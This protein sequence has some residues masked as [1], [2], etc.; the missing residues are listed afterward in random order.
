[1]M[2]IDRDVRDSCPTSQRK[3]SP[4]C[5][6]VVGDDNPRMV[7]AYSE[8]T[9]HRKIRARLSE[10]DI[11]PDAASRAAGFDKTF[12]R[13]LLS[14]TGAVPRGDNLEKLADVLGVTSKWL[15][16]ETDAQT[17]HL[18]VTSE[19]DLVPPESGAVPTPLLRGVVREANVDLPGRMQMPNDVPVYGTAAGSLAK[20][21]FQ[22][23][24]GVIE[25]VRRPPALIGSK[26]I[27]ALY[28][29]G[30]SMAPEHNPGDLRFVHTMKPPKAGDSVIVQVQ[31]HDRDDVEAYIGRYMRMTGT[32]LYL[33]KLNPEATVQLNRTYVKAI[34]KVLTVNEMF[35]V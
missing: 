15:L 30:D 9:L 1:M 22:F 3:L 17:E 13:K 26:V 25:F 31:N 16:D 19:T 4:L 33:G 32:T 24:G 6:N 29:E 28:V 20:G 10:L 21:A 11:T 34:H 5:D 18:P 12:L 27:Y 8:S 23:E 2:Q 35:G 7:Q 14:R